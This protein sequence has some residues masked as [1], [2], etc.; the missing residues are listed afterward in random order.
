MQTK[1]SRAPATLEFAYVDGD[2]APEGDGWS[3]SGQ[4]WQIVDQEAVP[5]TPEQGHDEFGFTTSATEG[6]WAATANAGWLTG[7]SFLHTQDS[8]VPLAAPYVATGVVRDLDP[9]T[10]IGWTRD[11]P[12]R[13]RVRAGG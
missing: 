6:P 3:K 1:R 11:R 7:Q 5:E 4:T 10:E 9:G 12:R 13:L 2:G 8:Y